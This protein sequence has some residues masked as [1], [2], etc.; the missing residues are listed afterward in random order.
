MAEVGN[1]QTW[2]EMEIQARKLFS[3]SAP[4]NEADLFSGRLE[5]I[6]RIV[7]AVAERGRHA[8]LYGER[9]VGKTSLGNIFHKL[10]GS[11]GIM[12]GQREC[13]LWKR[14]YKAAFCR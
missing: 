7:N 2:M 3:P 9:G 8:V 13:W 6:S 10:T 14:I 4:I 11:I 12:R 5:Q 1:E